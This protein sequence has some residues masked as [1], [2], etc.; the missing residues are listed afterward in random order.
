MKKVLFTAVVSACL[1]GLATHAFAEPQPHM[2]AALAALETARA[3]LEKASADKGGH[4]VKA[5]ALV[6]EAIDQ[7]KKGIEFDNKH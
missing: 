1:G 6:T 4:R 7:V 3:Q 2:K 5:I